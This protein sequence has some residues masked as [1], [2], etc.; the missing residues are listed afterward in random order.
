MPRLTSRRRAYGKR[1][2]RRLALGNHP[3]TNHLAFRQTAVSLTP[4][5][6]FIWTAEDIKPGRI[7]C[8]PAYFHF[9][10][11]CGEAWKPTGGTA[12]WTQKIGYVRGGQC[13]DDTAVYVLIALTD[14]MVGTAYTKADI[15]AQLNADDMMPMPHKW[16][17]ETINWLRDCYE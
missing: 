1:R 10:D 7:V 17:I 14:G 8:K 15:A 11:Q 4:N 5:M 6:K 9:G 12:K 13:R 16:L 2:F 3:Y